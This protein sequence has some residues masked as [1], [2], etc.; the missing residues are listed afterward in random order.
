VWCT[1]DIVLKL[2]RRLDHATLALCALSATLVGIAPMGAELLR[3]APTPRR[4]VYALFN[5]SLAFFLL[6][7]QVHEKS[8]LLPMLP[9]AL[10]F[11]TEEAP[12]LALSCGVVAAFSTFPLLRR[13][14]QALAYVATQALFLLV[15]LTSDALRGAWVRAS[16]SARRWRVRLLML[17]FV[18]ML[19]LHT[20]EAALAPPWRYPDLYPVL[21]AAFSCAHFCVFFVV[22]NYIQWTL[23]ER[24]SKQKAT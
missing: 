1:L 8:I 5:S 9:A 4:F 7:Y 12:F 2:R 20:C 3:R 24:T 11:A 16:A 22:G 15:A 23:V 19:A 13:D 10:L 6:S 21:F 18:G 17:S 14:G